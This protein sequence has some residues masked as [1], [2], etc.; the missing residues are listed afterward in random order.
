V[1]F[2]TELFLNDRQVRHIS[3]ACIP[4]LDS[5][6]EVKG[7]I[8]LVSDISDR[9]ATER[10]KDE[11]VSVVSHELRTPLTSIYGALKLLVTNP[12]S[13]LS[14]DDSEMLTIAVTNTERLIRLVNDIL[15]LERIKSGKIKMD[16][17]PCD[18]ADLLDK[19][20]E[21][22]LPMANS[23]NI[24]LVA[25]PISITVN[26]DRDRIH[27]TLTNLLSNAIKFSPSNSSIWLTVDEREQEVLFKVS[28]RGRGIPAD[29]LKRIFE[30]FQQVNASDSRDKGG[31]GLGLTICYKIIEE[32]GGRIW[33]ESQLNQGSTFYFT[34]PKNSPDS[35]I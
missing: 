16:K 7:F 32:H 1:T 13:E 8:N 21:V 11:F 6:R 33:A 10:M 19:A 31:T 34:L 3:A 35:Q 20:V 15:D 22:M 9:K 12:E 30:K 2:E 29:N 23:H 27:Q 26:A 18:T 4:D 5:D 28:D 25:E 24:N 17:Q 14:E